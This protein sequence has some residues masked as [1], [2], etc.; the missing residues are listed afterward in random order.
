MPEVCCCGTVEANEGAGFLI[1]PDSRHLVAE[2]IVFLHR[3]ACVLSRANAYASVD[4]VVD[5]IVFCVTGVLHFNTR[6]A[7]AAELLSFHRFP[8]VA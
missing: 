2:E 6:C 7:G 1:G 3:G 5:D 4:D 8:G